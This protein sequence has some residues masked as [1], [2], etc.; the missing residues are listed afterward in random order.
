[1]KNP[2]PSVGQHDLQSYSGLTVG[3]VLLLAFLLRLW[4]ASGTFLNLDEAMHFLAANKP[5]LVEAYRSSLNLAHPPLLILLLNVWRSLG[6]SELFLRLPS[7]IAGTIFCWIF[8]RWLTRI[9]GPAVGCIGFGL[10]CL[11][12]VFIEL[13]AEVRQYPL[14]LCF[15]MAA[16][17]M[18]ELALS[19]NSAGKMVGFFIFLYLAMLTHFSAMLFAGAVAAYSLWRLVSDRPSRRIVA[20]W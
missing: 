2:A 13:S 10:V 14:L 18:L 8:F 12:P 5:S 4:K 7:V 1:M 19:E 15:M 3:S 16:A 6:T 9:L 17:C 20:I 11:L